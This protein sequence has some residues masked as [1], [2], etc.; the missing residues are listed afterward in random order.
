MK[1]AYHNSPVDKDEKCPI[2]KSTKEDTQTLK[3]SEQMIYEHNYGLKFIE[4]SF[5]VNP[6][7]HDCGVRCI[8]HAPTLE[9][10]VASFKN[11]MNILM[12]QAHL[13]EDNEAIIKLGGV[14]EL[15]ALKDSMTEMEMVVKSMLQQKENVSMEYVSDLVKAMSDV[16]VIFDELTEMGYGALPSPAV[17]AGGEGNPV[18]TDQFSEPASPEHMAPSQAPQ[19]PTGSQ[20]S[21]MGGLGN[22]TMPKNSSRKIED[23]LEINKN[24]ISKVSS[25]E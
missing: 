2:C 4:N 10:K 20:T 7:C 13:E 12:K 17:T 19:A 16:Q 6:A 25:L 23:F 3:H 24:I 15:N 8:L 1:C 22:V 14:K 5:V 21:D 11:T 9:N 18:V